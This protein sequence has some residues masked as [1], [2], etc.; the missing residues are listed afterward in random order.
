MDSMSDYQKQHEKHLGFR[1]LEAECS[2]NAREGPKGKGFISIITSKLH[3]RDLDCMAVE[4]EDPH[5][6]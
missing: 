1:V 2:L 3:V 6:S 5:V 4:F